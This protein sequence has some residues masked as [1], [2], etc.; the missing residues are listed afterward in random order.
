MKKILFIIMLFFISISTTFAYTPT[1]ADQKMLD[2]FYPKLESILETEPQKLEKF[3]QVINQAKYKFQS[4][5]NLFYILSE[6]AEYSYK[7]L[8]DRDNVEYTVTEVVDWDT[9][10]VS[11][12]WKETSVRLIGI[13]SPE[14]YKTRFWYIECYW[15]EAKAYLKSLIEWKTIKIE[16]DTTQGKFDKYDRLLGYVFYN[17]ENI[18]NKMIY[19]WYAWEY[20]YSTAYKYQ[21]LFQ[22]S[23]LDA[24]YYNK[25]LWA[26]NTCN[27]ERLN[28]EEM[29]S[30]D[31]Q[32]LEDLLNEL[33]TSTTTTTTTT[34]RTY[35]TWPRWWCYYINSNWNKT[36]VDHSYCY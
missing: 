11:Y 15:E 4:K 29:N 26:Y 19:N 24:D 10:K 18:N 28:V 21:S 8:T 27:W 22:K 17:W 5:E 14:S 25:W 32:T 9:V 34:T 31:E 12:L 33:N 35:Y 6:L 2:N 23:E 7:I 30:D 13:D 20:T 36:Y 16:L 1:T 3:Y